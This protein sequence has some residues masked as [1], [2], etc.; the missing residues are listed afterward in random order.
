MPSSN[1]AL[2]ISDVASLRYECSGDELVCC[3]VAKPLYPR[4]RRLETTS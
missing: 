3:K 2:P 4:L 1:I